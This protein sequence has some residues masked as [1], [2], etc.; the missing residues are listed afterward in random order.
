MFAGIET[1]MDRT[2]VPALKLYPTR[3]HGSDGTYILVQA[4]LILLE[5]WVNINAGFQCDYRVKRTTF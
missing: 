1:T 3:I 5:V 2:T 4:T